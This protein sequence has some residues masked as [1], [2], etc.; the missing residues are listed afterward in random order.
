M[1][2]NRKIDFPVT[3]ELD[4]QTVLDVLRK[5]S[6]SRR[7]IT[8]LKRQDVGIVIGDKSVRTIDRVS[9]GDIISIYLPFDEESS[10]VANE[11]LCVPINYEDSDVVVFDKPVNMPV[12][13]SI[14]HYDDTLANYFTAKFPDLSFRPINRLDKDTSG[15]CVVAKNPHSAKLLQENL[16]K[17]Y[18]AVAC[19]VINC[20]G[21]IDAPIGRV[22]ASIIKREVRSDGQ[23]AVTNYS[24]IKSNGKYTLLEVKLE[25]GRTHQ[26]RVHF[27]HIGFPLA[28]DDFYGGS[29]SDIEKTALHCSEVTF[30]SPEKNKEITLKSEIRPDMSALIA[31]QA[32]DRPPRENSLKVFIDNNFS[33]HYY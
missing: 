2:Y 5:N 10:A 32:A 28:G 21:K 7:L 8:K 31:G 18:S 25:T 3:S 27:S 30:F 16:T 4:G 24:P 17:I 12:H 14:L 11:S 22:D 1:N 29:L 23:N 9:S 6:V 33:S 20:S 19:G 13:P 15:L 26:I